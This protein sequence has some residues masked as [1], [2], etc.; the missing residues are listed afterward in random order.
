MHWLEPKICLSGAWMATG[1]LGG[2][3]KRQDY[4]DA[5]DGQRGA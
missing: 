3:Q 5:K 4:P 1:W 2:H